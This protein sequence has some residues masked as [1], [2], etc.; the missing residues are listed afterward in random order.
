[1]RSGC[2]AGSGAAKHVQRKIAKTTRR[3]IRRKFGKRVAAIVEACSDSFELPKA[4]WLKRKNEHLAKIRHASFSVRLVCAADKLHNARSILA[5]YRARGERLWQ[6]FG[7]GREGTLW[8][9]REM[10]KALK[11]PGSDPLVKELDLVVTEIEKLG[12]QRLSRHPV[13]VNQRENRK[14]YR[15]PHKYLNQPADRVR[16]KVGACH[17]RP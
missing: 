15:I 2:C 4:P 12:Y 6:R 11:R 9:Y 8:Y 10:A 7:G 1:M 14:G 16:S 13:C 17:I 3:K 5:D